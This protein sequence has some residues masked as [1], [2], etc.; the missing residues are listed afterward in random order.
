MAAQKAQAGDVDFS[1][2]RARDHGAVEVA[3]HDIAHPHRGAAASGALDLSAAD[4][5]AFATAEI[6]LDGGDEPRS[7]DIEL[8]G[9]A[10]EPPPQSADAEH[11]QS[12]KHSRADT[13]PP[14]QA[15]M[16]GQQPPVSG[17]VTAIAPALTAASCYGIAPAPRVTDGFPR[18]GCRIVPVLIRHARSGV[19]PSVAPS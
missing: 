17:Q 2:W 6:I 1:L 5:D 10:G 11:E 8:D 9:A 14:D 4:F 19:P 3:H 12:D 13:D 18:R 7:K 15:L 16:P